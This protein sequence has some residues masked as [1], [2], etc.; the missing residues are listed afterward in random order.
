MLINTV[1]DDR[2]MYSGFY[3]FVVNITSNNVFML[4]IEKKEI[5]TNNPH[6]Y[7]CYC[8]ET[9]NFYGFRHGECNER[10]FQITVLFHNGAKFDYRLIIE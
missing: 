1:P 2:L 4:S 7:H 6:A 5:L 9:G 8:K 10:K 3:L